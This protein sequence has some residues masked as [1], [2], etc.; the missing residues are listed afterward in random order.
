M[1]RPRKQATHPADASFESD[2]PE[3]DG[4][5]V[6]GADR[7]P[8]KSALKRQAHELQRL[9]DALVALRPEQLAGMPID[10]SLRDALE[11]A[12]RIKSREGLRRQRQLIGK[13]MRDAD[14]DAIRDALE[15]GSA[16]HR[17]EVALA[18]AAEDW[19]ERL[20]ADASALA[21][22]G[23]RFGV[24]ADDPALARL[25]DQARAERAGTRSGGAYRSLYRHLLAAM[26]RHQD[27]GTP[28][29]ARPPQDS[30]EQP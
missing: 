23:R 6:D 16:G 9:G 3:A 8:S 26:R 4:I 7:R 15:A 22:F 14:A 11:L 5:D 25:V 17:A 12:R 1:S 21:A 13:L 27:G 18:R 19:R 20:L 28:K 10:E 2:R 30:P 29:A 24:D